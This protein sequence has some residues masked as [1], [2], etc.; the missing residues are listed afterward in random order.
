MELLNHYLTQVKLYLKTVIK[1][2]AGLTHKELDWAKE[3]IEQLEADSIE[4]LEE[5]AKLSAKKPK[6]PTKK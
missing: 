6:K 3:R 4:L 2:I 5:V 1:S